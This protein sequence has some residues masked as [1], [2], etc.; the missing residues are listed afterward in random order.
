MLERVLIGSD[1]YH[2]SNPA[3]LRRFQEFV[4][5]TAPYDVIIDGLNV[6]YMGTSD[7]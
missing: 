5:K 6:G 1:V 4:G 3:E 2:N 7:F